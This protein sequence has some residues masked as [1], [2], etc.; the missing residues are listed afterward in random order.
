MNWILTSSKRLWHALTHPV[1]E[2]HLDRVR[3]AALLAVHSNGHPNLFWF[4]LR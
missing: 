2:L 4:Q 1:D 3:A